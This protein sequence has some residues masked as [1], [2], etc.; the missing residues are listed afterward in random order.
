MQPKSR[1]VLSMLLLAVLLLSLAAPALAE[2]AI[3]AVTS[4]QMVA[5]KLSW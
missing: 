2:K 1:R 3:P 4:T 5:Q